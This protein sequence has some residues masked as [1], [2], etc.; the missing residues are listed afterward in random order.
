MKKTIIL[1]LFTFISLSLAGC[2]SEEGEKKTNLADELMV[3]KLISKAEVLEE[4]GDQE[5][6]NAIYLEISEKYTKTESFKKAKLELEQKGISIED[7]LISKTSKRMF[8]LQNIILRYKE[9]NGI[10]PKVSALKTE[11]DMWGSPLVLELGANQKVDWEFVIISMGPDG[12]LKT[13]DDI[14]LV[15]TGEKSTKILMGDG[16]VSPKR[17]ATKS[18][19]VSLEDLT[20][21]PSGGANAMGNNEVE[22]TRS[23]KSLSDQKNNDGK[24]TLSR[25]GDKE[26]IKSLDDL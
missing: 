22:S 21:T 9:R 23:L 5:G 4:R 2:S 16:D 15:Y 1:G 11:N 6:A 26:E 25:T 24:N 19:K 20:N 17:K 12:R 13:K 14:Y 3:Q 7:P 8:N 10:Y 18:G